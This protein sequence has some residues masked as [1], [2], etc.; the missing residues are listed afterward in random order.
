MYHISLYLFMIPFCKLI[1]QNP[2][3]AS[4]YS[5]EIKGIKQVI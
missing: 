1:D 3:H 4:V 2:N 5:S